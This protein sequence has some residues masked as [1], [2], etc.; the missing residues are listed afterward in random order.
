[1]KTYD[2]LS[3][4]LV[5]EFGVALDDLTPDA[6]PADLGLDSFTMIEIVAE[7]E[8]EFDV[9]FAAEQL[10]FRTLGEAAAVAD[11]LIAAKGS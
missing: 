8:E 1:M 7:L 6:T 3:E 5:D 10:D 9:K 4:L 2:F 11:Q